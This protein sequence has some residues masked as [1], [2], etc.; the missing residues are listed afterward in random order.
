MTNGFPFKGHASPEKDLKEIK[1]VILNN[2]MPPWYYKPFHASSELAPE[3]KNEILNWINL[4][5]TKIGEIK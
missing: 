2:S 5:L 4:S 3:E 1:K